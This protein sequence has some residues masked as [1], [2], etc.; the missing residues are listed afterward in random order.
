MRGLLLNADKFAGRK[1]GFWYL[2]LPGLWGAQRGQVKAKIKL[3]QLS[4]FDDP[5]LLQIK[6]P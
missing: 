1:N 5:R 2:I 3:H 6:E 4:R